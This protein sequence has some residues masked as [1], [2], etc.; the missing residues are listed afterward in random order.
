[1]GMHIALF[2]ISAL[3]ASTGLRCSEKVE[4][5]E[6]EKKKDILAGTIQ[7]LKLIIL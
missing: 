4:Q 5:A 3:V 6:P 2:L 1:M 7:G